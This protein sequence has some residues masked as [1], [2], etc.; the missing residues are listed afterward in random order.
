MAQVVGRPYW[1][2]C[3]R[4]RVV[5]VLKCSTRARQGSGQRPSQLGLVFLIRFLRLRLTSG[6]ISGRFLKKNT[7]FFKISKAVR[8]KSI[9]I[10]SSYRTWHLHKLN[11]YFNILFCSLY[12]GER[13]TI[14]YQPTMLHCNINDFVWYRNNLNH[15]KKNP[16][17][18]LTLIFVNHCWDMSRH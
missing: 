7:S 10:L 5:E 17:S 15:T 18:D 13:T 4:C 14:Q 9:N 11:K 8:K 1:K 2:M 3:E 6:T 12:I 16:R